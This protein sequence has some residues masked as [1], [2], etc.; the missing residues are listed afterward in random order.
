MYQWC[1]C[2]CFVSF[3]DLEYADVGPAVFSSTKQEI[4][5][6]VRGGIQVE[7]LFYY[8][9]QSAVGMKLGDCIMR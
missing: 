6:K 1:W 3:V 8:H 9:V 7:A 4:Q 5:L 2:F